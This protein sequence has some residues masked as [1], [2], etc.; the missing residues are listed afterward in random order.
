VF[1]AWQPD[2]FNKQLKIRLGMGWCLV[3]RPMAMLCCFESEGVSDYETHRRE[4]SK[5][6]D[7]L[8]KLELFKGIGRESFG[9]S[10]YPG[11]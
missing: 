9:L 4:G 11:E 1:P 6:D 5:A 7:H 3:D 2:N 10:L 8:E